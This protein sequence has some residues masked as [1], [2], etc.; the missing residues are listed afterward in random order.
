MKKGK[1]ITL[2]LIGITVLI[3]FGAIQ[4]P[5][6]REW[7]ISAISQFF[8]EPPTEINETIPY[9]PEENTTQ[10]K[11]KIISEEEKEIE[12]TELFPKPKEPNVIAI[13]NP[14][15]VPVEEAD[16]WMQPYD[17]VIYLIYNGVEKAYPLKILNWHH[18]VNDYAGS[19]PIVITYSPLSGSSVAFLR[20]VN[21][22][23]VSFDVSDYLWRSSLLMKD[24]SGNSSLWSQIFGEAITGNYT[25]YKLERIQCYTATWECWKEYYPESQVLSIDTGYNFSYDTN[26]YE[27]YQSNDYVDYGVTFNDTRLHPKTIVYS[28][29]INGKQ[30]A[31]PL[32]TIKDM[33]AINDIVNDVPILVV[34]DYVMDTAKIF[35]RKTGNVTLT[36]GYGK[37]RL[38][39]N[40]GYLWDFNGEGISDEVFGEKLK[41]VPFMEIFWFAQL[42]FYPETELYSPQTP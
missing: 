24:R 25:G 21:D 33:K 6:I 32:E 42:A 31:Y 28:V 14:K 5:L 29:N 13:D 8:S 23:V 39:D 15:F 20:I 37:G 36:F 26:P 10:E 16:S 12:I 1:K 30:K 11:L 40:N 38:I 18:I 3:F 35:E 4:S 2:T 19:K 27:E 17:R 9:Q 22:K 7:I 34:W 41:P